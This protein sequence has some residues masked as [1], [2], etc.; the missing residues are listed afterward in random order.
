MAG[1]I[2]LT[3]RHGWFSC[4]EAFIHIIDSMFNSTQVAQDHASHPVAAADLVAQLSAHSHVWRQD[5][6][7]FSIRIRIH[8]SRRE[9]EGGVIR[10]Y[11][12][13]DANTLLSVP[14]IAWR[15]RHYVN[16]VVAG[17]SRRRSGS[18]WTRR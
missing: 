14:I 8:R 4:Y 16:V 6:N 17:S 10:I 3:G 15:S 5:H 18:T 7:G 1:G 9:Q 12:P 13:P 2:T 11:L